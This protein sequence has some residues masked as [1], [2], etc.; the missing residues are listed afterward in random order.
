M[1]GWVVPRTLVKDEFTNWG[2]ASAR[3]YG[4]WLFLVRF[5]CPIAITAIFLHQ[6]KWI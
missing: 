5:V 6:M 4:F 3:F 1:V 2:T